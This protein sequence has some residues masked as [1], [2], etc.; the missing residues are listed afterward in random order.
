MQLDA[1]ARGAIVGMAA[2]GARAST[3]A[4]KVTKPD[5]SHPSKRAVNQTIAKAKSCR[6][7]RG[8]RK[9]GSG[10]PAELPKAL[11]GKMVRLVFR[12]RARAIVNIR[13]C[14]KAIPALRKHSR[15][16]LARGLHQAG[17]AWLRRRRKRFVPPPVREERCQYGRWILRQRESFLKK[18]AY[19]DGTTYYL[20]RSAGENADQ[21]RKRLG[22]F[23]WR[24]AGGKDG[25]FTDNVGPSLYAGTQGQPVKVWGLLA[26]GRVCLHILPAGAK[27]D[28]TAHMNGDRFRRMI[29]RYSFRWLRACFGRRLPPT[30]PLVMDYERCLRTQESLSCLRRHRLHVVK[31]HPKYSPDLN[32]IEEVWALI[33]QILNDSQPTELESRCDFVKRLRSAAKTLNRRHR[34]ALLAMC[35]NQK[36]RARALLS[37]A[38]ATTK[39]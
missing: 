16:V 2:A 7:W 34:R 4:A 31:R 38:G 22:A 9:P 32:A 39:W 21:H 5:G 35:T 24:E 6:K 15:Y 8:S 36:V 12:H 1:F 14:K 27:G 18:W 19:V 10:R 33:R 13:F 37:N 25:L 30:V 26:S 20:A 11:L 23:V 17:L 29:A 3:I 28:D